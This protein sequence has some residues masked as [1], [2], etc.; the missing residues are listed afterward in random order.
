V[1]TAVE[2]ELRRDPSVLWRWVVGGGA[3]AG[4][5]GQGRGTLGTVKKAT[6]DGRWVCR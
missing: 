2:A 6:G 4:D 3:V 1:A 5:G